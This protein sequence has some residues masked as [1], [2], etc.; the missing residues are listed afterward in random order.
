MRRIAIAVMSTIS[1]LVLLFS[2]HTS[3]DSG[4]G[5]T[6][7]TLA[8][9]DTATTPSDSASADAG[10]A[11]GA[12]PAADSPTTGASTSTTASATQNTVSGT[13]TGDVTDTRW[14]PVQVRIVVKNSK[15]IKATAIQFP[16]GNGHDQEINSWAIPQLQQATVASNGA[17]VDSL[18]GATVTSDGY[19]G[20]LQSALDQ[21]HL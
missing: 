11:D 18:S 8:G 17:Q 6:T 21:A 15:I 3:L 9:P 19:K 14:G 7:T 4:G 13:F 12:S 10:A 5:S 20:S 1:G 16:D 2:Y